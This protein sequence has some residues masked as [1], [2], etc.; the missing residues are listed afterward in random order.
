MLFHLLF[1]VEEDVD[2]SIQDVYNKYNGTNFD[3]PSRAIDYV[4]KQVRKKLSG[5]H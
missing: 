3:A 2:N 5:E 4:Q 1:Q